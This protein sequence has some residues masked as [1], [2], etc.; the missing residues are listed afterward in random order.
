MF[1]YRFEN[2]LNKIEEGS[3]VVLDNA[4]YHSRQVERIPNMSWRKADIQEWLQQKQIEFEE[5][6]IKAQLLQ[7]NNKN[8]YTA[9]VVDEMAANKNIILLRLPP[10]H[11]ELNP[12]ELIWAQVKSY[13]GRRNKTF[14]MAEIKQL[15]KESLSKIDASSWCKAIDHVIKEEDKMMTLDDLIDNAT[16]N[17][18]LPR[19]SINIAE[20]SSSESDSSLE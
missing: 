12:I 3:V 1:N 20:S 15:L 16:D 14:K 8:R 17:M 4:P 5:N 18:P 9:K 13:V 6:E 19:F 10:Y 2:I 11:C 7:K